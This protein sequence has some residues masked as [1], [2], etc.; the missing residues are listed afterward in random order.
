M[1]LFEL[2]PP[3]CNFDVEGNEWIYGDETIFIHFEESLPR[4]RAWLTWFG[5]EFLNK[6]YTLFMSEI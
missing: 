3:D 5:R 6:G 2:G 1:Y 4:A